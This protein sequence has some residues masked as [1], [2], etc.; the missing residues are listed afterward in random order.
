LTLTEG[1]QLM[2]VTEQSKLPSP[3]VYIVT[4]AGQCVDCDIRRGVRLLAPSHNAGDRTVTPQTA[5]QMARLFYAKAMVL[6]GKLYLIKHVVPRSC[7]REEILPSKH[8]LA[9]SAAY[10]A[11]LAT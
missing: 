9:R 1:S 6:N 11:R 7:H 3:V 5:E 10:L 2:L 4:T 8:C